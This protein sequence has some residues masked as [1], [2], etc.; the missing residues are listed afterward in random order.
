MSIEQKKFPL[1]SIIT[2][3][4][5]H[6]DGLKR[7]CESV[8]SQVFTDYEW[9]VID[10]ASTDGSFDFLHEKRKEANREAKPFSFTS[11]VDKGIYDAMNIGMQR[12]CGRYLIFM[13][14]GDCFASAKTLEIIAPHTEKKPDFI[15]GDALETKKN[16]AKPH[17]KEARQYKEMPWGMFTHHQAMIYSRLKVRDWKMHYSLLYKIAADYDFTARFLLNANKIIY[18]KQ[19]ICLF[20]HGGISQKQ[21]FKGRREQYIIREKLEMLS[22]AKNLGIFIAQS[23]GWHIKAISPSLYD[24]LK[25]LLI[26]KQ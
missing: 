10:G 4:L 26:K 1:F 15:Y 14:A 23:I 6:L 21:A 24:V 16:N 9:L 2:V 19:P 3:N 22:Q 11:E 20:E 13:N 25:A 5:N 8:E 7:T 12:A 18:I 17:Y